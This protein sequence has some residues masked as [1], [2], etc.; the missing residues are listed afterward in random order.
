MDMDCRRMS[1]QCQAIFATIASCGH[2][3]NKQQASKVGLALNKIS[4][5][6]VQRA[7]PINLLNNH[8]INNF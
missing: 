1:K 6:K 4:L 3:K 8:M 7:S 2:A 5:I